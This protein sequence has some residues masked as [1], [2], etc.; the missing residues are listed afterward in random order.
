LSLHNDTFS[1]FLVHIL[2][3]FRLFIS[4][5]VVALLQ[6]SIFCSTVMFR[7]ASKNNPRS[8]RG[9]GTGSLIEPDCARHIEPSAI[10]ALESADKTPGEPFDA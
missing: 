9:L 10:R 1:P 4:G 3:I 5:T 6:S 2:L 7:T 8:G